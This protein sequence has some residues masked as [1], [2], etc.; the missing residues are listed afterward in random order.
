MT[1]S[2]TS[3]AAGLAP[4]AISWG[5]PH[6][7]IFA[8]TNNDTYSIYRKYRNANATSDTEFVPDGKKMELVGG[9]VSNNSAPSI[10]VNSR[11]TDP[12]T[13]QTEIHINGK[14]TGY[15]K[16][17]DANEVW[18]SD[19]LA[20]VMQG[21]PLSTSLALRLGQLLLTPASLSKDEL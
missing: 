16:Y 1:G 10:A 8:L 3:V 12:T 15:R 19:V 13:Y 20:R 14:G 7:E 5:Y 11:M 9:S 2:P 18:V 4:T 17:H 21:L 6:L